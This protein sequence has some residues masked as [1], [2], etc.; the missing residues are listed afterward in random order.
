MNA[1]GGS[2][3]PLKNAPSD[4]LSKEDLI[5]QIAKRLP[6]DMRADYYRLLRYCRSLPEND[7]LLRILNAMQYLT[8]LIVDVPG[9]VLIERERLEQLFQATLTFLDK[10]VQSIETYQGQ[11]HEHLT[12]VPE[13][14]RKKSSRKRSLR[15]SMRACGSN[16]IDQ[17]YLKRQKDS[18]PS[19][20]IWEMRPRNFV[21]QLGRLETLTMAPRRKLGARLQFLPPPVLKPWRRSAAKPKSCHVSTGGPLIRLRALAS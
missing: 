4:N 18:R 12:K 2:E 3:K 16:L 17:R 21:L 19:L 20:S 9:R 6:G 14:L 11:L 5:D 13:K 1:N 8:L 7:E 10:A 15:K